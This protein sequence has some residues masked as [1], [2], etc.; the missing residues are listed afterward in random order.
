[1]TE[2]TPW[3]DRF[4]DR[5]LEHPVS[6]SMTL[7][8]IVL[9]AWAIGPAWLAYRSLERFDGDA[10]EAV[11]T[12]NSIAQ[13]SEPDD[14]AEETEATRPEPIV[15]ETT[16]LLVGTDDRS[17]LDDL[18]D[19][20][21]FE[22]RRADVVVVAVVDADRV[23]ARLVS[24]PRD[25]VAPDLC[26]VHDEIRLADALEGCRT[27]GGETLL[28]LTVEQITGISIDHVASVDLEGFQEAVDELGGYEICVEHAVRDAASGLD[29]DAGC[30]A[31]SGEQTLAWIRSRKTEELVDGRWRTIP[32][33]ND[34]ARNARERQFLTDMFQRIIDA[35]NVRQ[36]QS[37]AATVAP[38]LTLDSS[39]DL[40]RLV[41]TG[42]SMRL[43]TADAIET[44][45]IPVADE[46]LRQ[47]AVLR[48]TVD[49]AAFLSE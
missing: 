49:V 41:Q 8:A 13:A 32:G 36:L 45:A 28:Q 1:M 23:E 7:G 11:E 16:F 33:A 12:L 2:H 29:L 43:L 3:W 10:D 31:A 9:A 22:G 48:P 6:W 34:L 27:I 19:F 17:G 14:A 25:L 40:P 44:V 18:T 35:T 46:T 26:G 24:L 20:G 30:T 15:G 5:F 37:L 47:M 21:D 42:W 4:Q 38:H 39:L